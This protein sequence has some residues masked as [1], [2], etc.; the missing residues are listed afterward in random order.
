MSS[1]T[2]ISTVGIAIAIGTTPPGFLASAK[3]PTMTWM[4]VLDVV[5]LVASGPAGVGMMVT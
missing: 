3:A 1:A 4:P 2:T 5:W